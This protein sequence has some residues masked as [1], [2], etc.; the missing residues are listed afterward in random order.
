MLEE[1]LPSQGPQLRGPQLR[2]L[3]SKGSL[4]TKIT[5]MPTLLA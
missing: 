1:Q 2:F 3:L 4:E 5:G